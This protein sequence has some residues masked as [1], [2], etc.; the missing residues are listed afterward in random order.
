MDCT[1]HGVAKSR[2]QLSDFHFHFLFK[3]F[4]IL[5]SLRVVSIYIPNSCTPVEC[6][7]VPFSPHPL[8]HLLCVGFLM[9]A[10]LIG[11]Q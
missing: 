6:K 1:F 4:S 3:D 5:S 10:I 11:V 8:Q 2:T 9:M 7:R